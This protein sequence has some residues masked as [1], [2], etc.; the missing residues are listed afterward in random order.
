MMKNNFYDLKESIII[1]SDDTYLNNFLEHEMN[2]IR[3][4]DIVSGGSECEKCVCEKCENMLNIHHRHHHHDIVKNIVS[5][6]E[7]TISHNVYYCYFPL[8]SCRK[9]NYVCDKTMKLPYQT[10][11]TRPDGIM[12]DF[13]FP[14]FFVGKFF[15][16][17]GEWNTCD[18]LS[19]LFWFSYSSNMRC[20][21]IL[22]LTSPTLDLYFCWSTFIHQQEKK[23]KENPFSCAWIISGASNA[24]HFA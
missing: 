12:A 13:F 3:S 7:E 1:M 24:K 8:S 6:L 22:Q 9:T 21:N 2:I 10:F 23:K 4:R 5:M 14:F 11:T 19:V 16:R 18:A 20:I 17:N 15:I